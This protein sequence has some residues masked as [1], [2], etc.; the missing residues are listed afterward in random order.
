MFLK[1][2]QIVGFERTGTLFTGTG[3]QLN[4][5]FGFFIFVL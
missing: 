5:D 4:D 2:R 3:E 1:G